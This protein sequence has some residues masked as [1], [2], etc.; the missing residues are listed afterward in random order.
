MFYDRFVNL[1]NERGI[2]PNKA[3]IEIG[4]NRT[5]ISKWK[6]SG[7]TPQNPCEIS[8]EVFIFCVKYSYYFGKIKVRIKT[9][10]KRI[11]KEKAAVLAALVFG[12]DNGSRTHLF[13]LGS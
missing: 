1:C 11:N 10:K 9:R 3:A 6:K 8:C 12:A 5:S 4:F 7:F 2:S 13:S